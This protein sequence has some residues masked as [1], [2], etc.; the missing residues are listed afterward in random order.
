VRISLLLDEDEPQL[1]TAER[2][3][4]GLGKS[5]GRDR[6]GGKS[7]DQLALSLLDNSIWPG[8]RFYPARIR[9]SVNPVGPVA[10]HSIYRASFITLAVQT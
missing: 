2:I 10:F 5:N 4:K 3:I 8:S 7:G 9:N 1:G 6:R